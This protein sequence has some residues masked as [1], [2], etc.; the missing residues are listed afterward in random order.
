ME[1]EARDALDL[2]K[3]A[4]TGGKY[5]L[6]V[7]KHSLRLLRTRARCFERQDHGT[8]RLELDSAIR[9]EMQPPDGFK[10]CSALR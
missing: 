9:P 8:S 6:L 1:T 5:S 10:N 4:M 2:W 3:S 7:R